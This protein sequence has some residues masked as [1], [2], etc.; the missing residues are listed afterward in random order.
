MRREPASFVVDNP[1][2]D[3]QESV[4]FL[5]EAAQLSQCVLKWPHDSGGFAFTPL[6]AARGTQL[7]SQ[8][9]GQE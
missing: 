7:D 8:Q 1:A 5:V 9:C 4:E 3:F 6:Q 2:L